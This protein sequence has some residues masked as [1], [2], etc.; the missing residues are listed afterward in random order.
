[1]KTY[2]LCDMVPSHHIKE[3]DQQL[4]KVN[5]KI[6]KNFIIDNQPHLL[7]NI[8]FLALG[9]GTFR[10]KKEHINNIDFNNEF[11]ICIK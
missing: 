1:M 11:T 2:L 9:Q 4:R 10:V 3:I 8:L 5:S 6:Q 7:K